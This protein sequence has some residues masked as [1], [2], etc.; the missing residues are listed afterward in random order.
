MNDEETMAQLKPRVL[1]PSK[2][3]ELDPHLKFRSLTETEDHTHTHTHT[4]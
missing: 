2:S 3:N 4:Q 1:W